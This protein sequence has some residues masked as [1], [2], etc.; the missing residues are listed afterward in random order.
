M[1]VSPRRD[2]AG[3]TMIVTMIGLT[4]IA[5]L[6]VVAVTAVNGDIHSSRYDLDQKQ[7]FEAAK[8]GIDDYAY[9]LHAE[10]SYWTHCATVTPQGAV[11][12]Q[13]STANK[14]TVPG[15]TGATYAIELLPSASQSKYTQCSTEN[16]TLSM[17]ESSGTLKGTFR[18]RSTGFAGK[19]KA[20][21]VAT[22]KPA[23][24]LDYVYFTQRETS[25]PVTYGKEAVINGAYEQ[26]SKTIQGGRYLATIPNSGGQYC[27]AISFVSGDSI[28]GPMHTNDAFV[29]CGNPTLGR[30]PTDPVEVA[31][32]PRGWFSTS[33]VPHSGS[34]CNGTEENFKGTFTANAGT[35]TPPPTNTELQN[36]AE[37]TFRYKG[38]VRICLNGSNMTVMT[39]T[40][41]NTC[42]SPGSIVY[43]GAVPANGVVYVE[44]G[45]CS[46]AYTP[47]NVQ[48]GITE[49]PS[50]CGNA[51]VQGNYSGQLTIAAA[52][53]IVVTNNICLESCESKLPFTG[54]GVL[55]LIANNFI[56]IYHPHTQVYNSSKEVWECDENG[57]GYLQNVR[58]DAALLAI[59]HSIIVDDYNCGKKLGT[60]TVNG[61]LAQK[62][63]GAV[64]TTGSSGSGYL[65]S[66]NYDNRLRYLSPP[67]FIEPEKSSWVIGRET[68]G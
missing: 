55:G 17:L 53:D 51:Y 58:I 19:T 3:F 35:L 49:P 1:H 64:G 5:M 2:E 48:Y 16:P 7:A 46:K 47:F 6:A 31:N 25:D 29:I 61:A 22:F 26:C 68:L 33:E 34:S 63:R 10:N 8:A 57:T 66:Y 60:L 21:I 38:Q 50:E 18:V 37:P 15:A 28:N 41:V 56:R 20:S 27:N 39:L 23:S 52:N 12:Q 67:S 42:A 30:E 36:I 65:K 14:R 11:N 32:P 13:G 44:S 45:A 59:D 54:L 24:F 62:Y 43:S 4:L 40:A 9:H